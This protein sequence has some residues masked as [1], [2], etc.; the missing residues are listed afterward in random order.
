MLGGVGQTLEGRLWTF[1]GLS[2]RVRVIALPPHPK[3][4][5]CPARLA[6][7]SRAVSYTEDFVNYSIIMLLF[8]KG[9]R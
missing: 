5:S 2:G 6:D 8:A 1:D 3:T 4:Q 9:D 7:V